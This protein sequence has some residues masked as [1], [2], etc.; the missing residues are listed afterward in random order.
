MKGGG[1]GRSGAFAK[2]LFYDKGT[3]RVV[4]FAC[5]VIFLAVF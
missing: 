2:Q 5:L 3:L 1:D 4:V